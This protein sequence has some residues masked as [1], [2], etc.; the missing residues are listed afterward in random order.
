MFQRLNIEFNKGSLILFLNL[1]VIYNLNFTYYYQ[2]GQVT[3]RI[4][5][6]FFFKLFIYSVVYGNYSAYL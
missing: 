1:I 2:C 6:F 3:A 4:V 5:I